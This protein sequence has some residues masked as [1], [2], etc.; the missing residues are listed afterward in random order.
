TY[1]GAALPYV[2]LTSALVQLGRIA[3]SREISA[4][5][6]LADPNLSAEGW[7]RSLPYRDKDLRA[8]ERERLEQAGFP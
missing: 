7:L 6:L 3:E 8:A 2:E 4:R 5:L 1:D